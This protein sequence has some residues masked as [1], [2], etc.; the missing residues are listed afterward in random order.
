MADFLR[1]SEAKIIYFTF[2]RFEKTAKPYRCKDAKENKN[3][4]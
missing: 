4:C 3:A 1:I 2:K